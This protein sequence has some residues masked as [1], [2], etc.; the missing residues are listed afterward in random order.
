MIL[1]AR[2]KERDE[3]IFH[4]W[5]VQLPYMDKDTFVPFSEYKE[6]VTGANIDRRSQAE[7]F[8]ELA[9]VEQLFLTEGETDGS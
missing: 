3:R 5:V 6:K 8:A 1:K 9:E 2:E 7:L 4:Q